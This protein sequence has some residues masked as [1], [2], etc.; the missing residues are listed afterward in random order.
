M[1]EPVNVLYVED[2][3]PSVTLMREAFTES[4]VRARVHSVRS[5]PAALAMLSG[6]DVDGP[7]PDVVLL[8]LDLG[9]TSGFDVLDALQT[10]EDR[11]VPPVVVFSSSDASNDVDSAYEMGANAYVQKPDDFDGLVEVAAG[12][13]RFWRSVE[14][15]A[16]AA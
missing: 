7:R 14:S 11:A 16:G 2:D 12:T 4:D 3:P 8:D 1:D 13:G 10:R 15:A 5:A 6:D 9:E